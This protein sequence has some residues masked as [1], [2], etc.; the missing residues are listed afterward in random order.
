MTNNVHDM[1]G[2]ERFR[3]NGEGG[4]G[5]GI[6]NHRLGE[7]ERRVTSLEKKVD[8]INGTAIEIKTKIGDLPTKWYVLW[9]TIIV[10]LVAF[11]SVAIHILIK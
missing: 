3:G 6:V 7:L 2:R 11:V 8:E 1:T 9:H 10:V 4:N 5:S